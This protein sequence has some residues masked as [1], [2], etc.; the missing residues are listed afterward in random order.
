MG[1]GFSR[2]TKVIFRRHTLCM[3][4]K[5]NEVWREKTRPGGV[6]RL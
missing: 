2:Q 6:S 1:E 4:R 3:S 5:I